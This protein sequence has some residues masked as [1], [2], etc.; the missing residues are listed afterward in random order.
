MFRN[1]KRT[2]D[3]EPP[4]IVRGR[5]KFHS[6]RI[7][8]PSQIHY[9]PPNL[10]KTAGDPLKNGVRVFIATDSRIITSLKI[11][12]MAPAGA[13]HIR[14]DKKA[15]N[16][17]RDNYKKSVLLKEAWQEDAPILIK[18]RDRWLR[19][20]GINVSSALTLIYRPKSKHKLRIEV[21]AATRDPW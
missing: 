1:A 13:I 21:Q 10:F 6:I 16:S 11:A 15:I 9:T 19:A 4:I 20:R 8:G 7:E 14:V 17:N 18:K 5:G 2:K 3:F 12:K